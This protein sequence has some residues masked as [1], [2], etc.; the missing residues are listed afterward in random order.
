MKEANGELKD[1]VAWGHRVGHIVGCMVSSTK[2][3]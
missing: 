2:M 3:Y 1:V